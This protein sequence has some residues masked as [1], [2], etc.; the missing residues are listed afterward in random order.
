MVADLEALG[1]AINGLAALDIEALGD[2]EL[3]ALV[4]GVQR[5]RARLGVVAGEL[6]GR[7]DARQVWANDGSRRGAPVERNELRSG[8]CGHG[9]ASSPPAAVAPGHGVRGP[10]GD[11]SLDHLDLAG[12]AN[13]AHRAACFA[14]DE[15]AVVEQCRTLRFSN[16]RLECDTHNRNTDRHHHHAV[17][18]PTRPVTPLDQIRARLR[19]QIQHDKLTRGPAP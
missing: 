14:R 19:W 13:Q 17:P 5:D 1:E 3:H 11:L 6:V 7:W 4:V 18:L 10:E 2:E 12:R 16:R 15:V 9:T 8:G